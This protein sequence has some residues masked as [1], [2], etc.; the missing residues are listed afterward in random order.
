MAKNGIL[1][2]EKEDDE[3]EDALRILISDP[4]LR[5][6]YGEVLYEKVKKDFY[7]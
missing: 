4:G 3:I 1:V 5:E 6:K 7:F 2:E